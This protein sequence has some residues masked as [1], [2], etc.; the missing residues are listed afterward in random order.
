VGIV[1]LAD[2]N[3]TQAERL[4]AIRLVR[5][6]KIG[7]ATY[8]ALIARF[9][10]A[11]KA[12]AA[13]PELARRG[14]RN[15]PFKLASESAARRELEAAEDIGAKIVVLGDDTYPALLAAT[16]PPPPL[17]CVLGDVSLLNRDCVAIVG[18]RNASAVAQRFTRLIAGDLGTSGFVVVSGMARGIDAAAHQGS[19]ATGTIAVLAGGVDNI[20]PSENK[21]LYEEIRERGAIA[22]EMP[23]G[24]A[25]VAAHFPR[26]NRIISG[27]SR[28]VV[29]VEAAIGSGSLIT[30]RFALEQNRE[31]FA[32]PGSPLDPRCKG[33]NNLIREGAT[34]TESAEDVTAVLRPILTQVSRTL[35]LPPHAL[36][37]IDLAGADHLRRKLLELL[38]PSPTDI[39]DLVRRTGAPE[40]E[41]LALI[42]ELELAGLVGRQPGRRIARI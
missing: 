28:G 26:R 3:V 18:A 37:P 13:V 4:A 39:D 25:P 35:P 24:F 36:L 19:I 32:V 12:L 10:T 9:G 2:G 40:G 20:Y 33:A 14:G 15:L 16:D 23:I 30:A 31:V 21:V 34:L 8:A 41:I 1:S 38:S 22:S 5:S 17:L 42:L 29:V 11:A 6:E 7:P 27:L